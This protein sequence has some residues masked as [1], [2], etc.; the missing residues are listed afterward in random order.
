[1]SE[2]NERKE[3]VNLQARANRVPNRQGRTFWVNVNACG[4]FHLTTT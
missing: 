3:S 2:K 1:M 4:Q